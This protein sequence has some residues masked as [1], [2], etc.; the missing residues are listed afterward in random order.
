MAAPPLARAGVIV[1]VVGTVADVIAHATAPRPYIGFTP[2]EQAGHLTILIGMVYTIAG[3]VL[4]GLRS[5]SRSQSATNQ[6]Q[7]KGGHYAHR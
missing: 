6:Q 4:D 7:T 5:R 1:I 2:Q 3:I